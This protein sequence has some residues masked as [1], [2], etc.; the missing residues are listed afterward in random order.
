M[1][2]TL[3]DLTTALTRNNTSAGADIVARN[4]E[5]LAVRSDERV[6]NA[7]ELARTLIATWEAVPILFNQIATVQ[8]DQAPRMGSA[9]ESDHEVVVETAVMRIG[10]NSRTVSTGVAPGWNRSAAPCRSIWS[11]SQ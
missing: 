4:G 3:Q 6:R 8:T 7:D 2:L 1:W 10:E 5:G 11:R 9:S